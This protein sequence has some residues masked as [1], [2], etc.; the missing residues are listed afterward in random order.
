M[1]KIKG[2]MHLDAE[3]VEFIENAK[4]KFRE[5]LG[6]KLSMDWE[7][8]RITLYLQDKEIDFE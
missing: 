6:I 7:L 4:S 5:S 8:D 1:E 2:I 3:S